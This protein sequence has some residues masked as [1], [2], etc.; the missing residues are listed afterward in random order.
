MNYTIEQLKK[1]DIP[2]K[3]LIQFINYYNVVVPIFGEQFKS[4]MRIIIPD[5]I[6]IPS[7]EHVI[8]YELVVKFLVKKC[9]SLQND[10]I[11]DEQYKDIINESF[12]QA[13]QFL[14]AHKFLLADGSQE[15][16]IILPMVKKNSKIDRD[17]IISFIN[18]RYDSSIIKKKGKHKTQSGE[19]ISA[20]IEEFQIPKSTASTYFYQLRPK[21]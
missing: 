11:N 2:F 20:I 14:N 3:S 12:E 19:I 6:P 10:E 13:Q 17:A 9:I 21:K 5:T 18:E 16:N 1:R 8:Y 4:I 15:S 7:Y